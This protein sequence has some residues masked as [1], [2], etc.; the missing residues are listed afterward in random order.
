MASPSPQILVV[1]DEETVSSLLSDFLTVRD[2]P[3]EAV[4]SGE[5]ALEFLQEQ[6]VPLVI[7]DLRMPGISGAPLVRRMLELV[8]STHVVIMTGGLTDD[9]DVLEALEAGAVRALHKPFKLQ[10]VQDLC[11]EFLANGL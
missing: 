3:H 4:D 10:E 2:Y 5:A 1:D 6:Q 7:C 11:Q 9:G 8:P